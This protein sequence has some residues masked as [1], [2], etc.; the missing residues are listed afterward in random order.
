YAPNILIALI[1]PGP[2]PLVWVISRERAPNKLLPLIESR[3]T[4]SKIRKD[5]LALF[6]LC[7]KTFVDLLGVQDCRLPIGRPAQGFI[8]AVIWG[9]CRSLFGC[10]DRQR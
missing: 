9:V 7:H 5:R 4:W 10:R 8:H 1:D 6:L 3:R 2:I